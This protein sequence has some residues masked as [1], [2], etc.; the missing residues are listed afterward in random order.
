MKMHDVPQDSPYFA[1]FI[2]GRRGEILDAAMRVFAE[3]GYTGGSM[4]DIAQRVGVSEPAIYKHFGSKE[5]LFLALLKLGALH[6][7]RNIFRTI[8]SLAADN[9]R[10]QALETIRSRRAMAGKWGPGFRNL[11][12]AAAKNPRFTAAYRDELVVP[13]YERL[14][15]KAAELDVAFDVPNADATRPQRVRALMALIVGFAVSSFVMQDEPDEAVMDAA[16]AIMDWQGEPV[17]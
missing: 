12:S 16:L 14:Q 7:H 9:L 3:K 2:A 8:D 1:E 11:M 4:R 15:D 5:D 6:A 10:E 13:I 17:G